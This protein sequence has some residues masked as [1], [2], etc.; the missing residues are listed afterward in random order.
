M[1]DRAFSTADGPIHLVFNL[2]G[3][4]KYGQAEH[5]YQQKVVDITRKCGA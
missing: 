3:E 4:T 5:V 1:R 2:A